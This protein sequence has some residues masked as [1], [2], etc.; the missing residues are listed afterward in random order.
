MSSC[1]QGPDPTALLLG[2]A[3]AVFV[4]VALIRAFRRET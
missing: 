1:T 4:T 2:L 3:G